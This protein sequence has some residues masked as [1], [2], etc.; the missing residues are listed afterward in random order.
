ETGAKPG[1]R[2]VVRVVE[3]D[4]STGVLPGVGDGGGTGIDPH[5]VER[6]ALESVDGAVLEAAPRAEQDD[7]HE[8]APRHAER[9][10]Q[11]AQLVARQRRP[12][13]GE[14]VRVEHG[15]AA[16][17]RPSFMKMVR[18]VSSATSRSCVTRMMVSPSWLMPRKSAMSS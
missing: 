9:R 2:D 5:R 18:S 14:S 1:Q 7:E 11:R 15:H 3:L 13:L 16:A 12:H 10:E 8:H 4:L 17:V 6:V